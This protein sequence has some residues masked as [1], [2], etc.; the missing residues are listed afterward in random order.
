MRSRISWKKPPV[1]YL[2]P[3]S[4][5][6][7][8]PVI[9]IRGKKIKSVRGGMFKIVGSN[10]HLHLVTQKYPHVSTNQTQQEKYLKYLRGKEK[11]TKPP[12]SRVVVKTHNKRY[13]ELMEQRR[14]ALKESNALYSQTR[15]LLIEVQKTRTF[16]LGQKQALV[17]AFNILKR[18][19][20]EFARGEEFF[21]KK[22]PK[23]SDFKL[24]TGRVG[25]ISKNLGK[26]IGLLLTLTER[27]HLIDQG[28]CLL[29]EASLGF[30]ERKQHFERRAWTKYS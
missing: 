12:V 10:E 7:K 27:D 4:V 3:T 2:R 28:T 24:A 21:L 14:S 25:F 20:D 1:T 11:K 30:K 6:G 9:P 19:A 15:K 5:I 13:S 18:N 17:E 23:R 8:A 29:L 16:N 22:N 26:L